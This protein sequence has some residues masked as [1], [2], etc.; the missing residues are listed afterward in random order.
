V[1]GCLQAACCSCPAAVQ[2]WVRPSVTVCL[3][4]DVQG[5][6][7]LLLLLLLLAHFRRLHRP[8]MLPPALLST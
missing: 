4:Q 3:L 6:Q 2:E 7:A 5:L 1:Q 8:P